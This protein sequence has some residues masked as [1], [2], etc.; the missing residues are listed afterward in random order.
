MDISATTTARAAGLRYT[1]DHQ[2][3]LVRLGKP[4]KFRYVD[5]DGQAVRDD[6]TLTRIKALAIPPAWTDVWICARANGHLQATGRDARGRKQYRYHARWRQVRDEVKYERMLSFGKALPAIRAAVARGM[7][8]PG[9]PREKVLATIVHLLELTMMR[10]GN[11]E[12][13][14]TNKSFGLTTLRTRH[15]QVDG[16]AVAFHFKGKSGVRHDI[17]LSDRRLARVLQR[18]RE[19]PGQELFQYVDD[20]GERHGVDSGA[21]NDYLREVTGEDYTAKDFRTWAGTLLAALALQAFELVDSDAQAK[22]NIVQAIESVA[23]KL[24]NTPTICRKCYVHPAVLEAYLDGSLLE[25]MRARARQQLQEDLPALA[26]EEAAVLALLQQ[27][28]QGEAKD[29]AGVRPRA[30]AGTAPTA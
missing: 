26:P 8:L 24:G 29:Q 27:R 28:L 20:A 4:A 3:G 9:L 23:K 30:A 17:R 21:V 18:M 11:E 22:K 16:S 10:I 2:P 1:G 15:V 19:L 7:Q 12:Y 14:R 6:D 25:G 5:A 13:A